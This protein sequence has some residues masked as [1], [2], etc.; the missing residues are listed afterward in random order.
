[1]SKKIG[2]SIYLW[3]IS[4]FSEK[5]DRLLVHLEK[6]LKHSNKPLV[7][8]TPNPEQI[9]LSRRDS[10][11]KVDLQA[12]DI[13]I[14]DGIGLIW[15]SRFLAGCGR[16][17]EALPE[18]ITGVDLVSDLLALAEKQQQTV[19]VV[20]GRNYADQPGLLTNSSLPG[21]V[22]WTPAYQRVAHPSQQEE[23]QLQTMIVEIKPDMIFVAFGAPHQERWAIRYRDFC[24][25]HGVSL[26]MVV[27]GSFD[28]LLGQVG[29][30]PRWLRQLGLEWLVRLIRQPWR[31]R[32]QLSLFS[33]V[34]LVMLTMIGIVPVSA[35]SD[36]SD[37]LTV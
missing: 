17:A 36:D 4:F 10:K 26:V 25:Q 7:M 23:Q 21:R 9:M 35:S 18:R 6:A 32:R 13:L 33:F 22:Y 15:A 27:G 2:K 30:A 24:Q 3:G 31:W 19:L 11:F 14:P 12:A 1:M 28:Y 37:I 5:K 20:G 29:R 8:A 16:I 34:Q